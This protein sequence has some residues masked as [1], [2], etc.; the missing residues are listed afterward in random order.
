MF[1]DKKSIFLGNN[2]YSTYATMRLYFE[3]ISCYFINMNNSLRL[4]QLI[5]VCL[6]I[7]NFSKLTFCHT[8]IPVRPD[9]RIR[10]ES[11]ARD[12]ILGLSL[13]CS[14]IR[15]ELVHVGKQTIYVITKIIYIYKR[16]TT[17]VVSIKIYTHILCHIYLYKHLYLYMSNTKTSEIAEAVR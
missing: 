2:T 13:T 3:S 6:T 9:W 15:A 7:L 8:P 17:G 14:Y 16:T 4:N 5:C 1:I 10:T 11:G 12:Y